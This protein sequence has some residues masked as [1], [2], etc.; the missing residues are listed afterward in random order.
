MKGVDAV[1]SILKRE[2]VE[3]L[4]CFPN[5]S[6]IDACAKIGIRP[7]LAR[8]ERTLI[9]MA[10]GYSRTTHGERL[11][12]AVVQSGPGSEN[13]FGGV[14]QAY[15]DS[16]PILL[17]PGGIARKYQDL[18]P[19]FQAARH[20]AGVT[21]WVGQINVAERA[22]A[23]LRRAFS[24][25]RMGHPR[26][27]ML[28][29]P[30]DVAGETIDDDI[31][32]APPRRVRS[33]GGPD[34]IAAAA[35]AL[36]A[37]DRPILHVGQGALY[38]QATEE[39]IA[40]A[41]LLNVPVMT[42]MAGKSAFPEDHPLSLGA[43]GHTVIVMVKH[44]LADAD[45]VFGLGCSFSIEFSTLIPRGKVMIQNSIDESDINKHYTIDHAIIGDCKL[46][47]QQL[48]D[49]VKQRLGEHG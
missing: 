36:L 8:T 42:T 6:L 25:L 39:L 41:E 44:F 3:F 13:A 16:V 23:M 47:V 45:L 4:F 29:I 22:P 40:L 32:Y 33:A 35:Q 7:I 43:G 20:Y 38:A 15:A 34:E 5:N 21:K 27:V 26:P 19:T 11:G 37:A 48:I 24:L 2:G 30:I 12:V 9:N 17:L 31:D 49:A 1:A 14:A 46:V 28:E 18:P 10:D